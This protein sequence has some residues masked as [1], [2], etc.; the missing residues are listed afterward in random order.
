MKRI[1][2]IFMVFMLFAGFLFADA[3]SRNVLITGNV[4]AGT[5]VN[6]PVSQDEVI[7]NV[8]G[9]NVVARV[10]TKT[11]KNATGN[12]LSYV[13]PEITS[14]WDTLNDKI[15]T[16]ED[17]LS[18]ADIDLMHTSD[19]GIDSLTINYG[20][21]GN[22]PDGEKAEVSVSISAEWTEGTTKDKLYITPVRSI[23]VEQNSSYYA[24][25]GT[26]DTDIVFYGENIQQT[27]I[28]AAAHGITWG[29]NSGAVIQAD[30]YTATITLT[31][32]PGVE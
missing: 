15:T 2:L 19:E 17:Y 32:S 14:S 28:V 30:E 6:P 13:A 24:S 9:L 26:S 4:A 7:I 11:D 22:V 16:S 18:Y 27:V 8:N 20:I 10:E 12:V 21:W 5:I 1:I 29:Y 31:F 25:A 23:G 3:T